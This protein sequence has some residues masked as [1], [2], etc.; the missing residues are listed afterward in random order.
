MFGQPFPDVGLQISHLRDDYNFFLEAVRNDART[1]WDGLQK[2]EHVAITLE[3]NASP[4]QVFKSLNSTGAPL[5]NHELIHN[6]ILMGLT[7]EQQTKIEDSFWVPIEENTG[8]AID[9][10][11]RDYLILTTGRDSE[12]RGEH[13]VYDVFKKQFPRPTIE[14]LIEHA[15][16]WKSYSEV[17]LILLDPVREVDNE[18]RRQL[19]YINTFGSAIFPFLLGV[20]RDYQRDVIDRNSLLEVLEQL[21]SLYLRRLVVGASRDHLAA[22]LCRK[23]QQYGYPISAIVRRTPP[24][25]RI[26]A[27]MRYRPLPH[28]GYVL[29]V[30]MNPAIWANWRSSTSSRSYPRTPGAVT[31]RAIGMRSTRWNALNSARSCQ[32][33]ATWRCWNRG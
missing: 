33:L 22:Q 19:H 2:L 18:I 11:L 7:Y 9:T 1:V 20:Y 8:D 27:A 15:A 13:G 10:F 17:Y 4:Q 14:S 28:A 6:Y 24:D 26:R 23:R 12:F 25:E 5:R 29:V 21:Q 16:E 30:S 31:E 32:Q 3:E